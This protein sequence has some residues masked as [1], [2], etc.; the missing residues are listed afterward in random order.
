M[1]NKITYQLT[2]H[3]MHCASCV[4]TIE[5]ALL[6]LSAVQHAEVNFASKIATVSLREKMSTDE[7]IQAM[8]AA[9]YTATLN[10]NEDIRLDALQHEQYIL[11]QHKQLLKKTVVAFLMGVPAFI[12]HLIA[13]PSLITTEGQ[14]LG[15]VLGILAFITLIYS[16]G[17][18]FSGAWTALKMRT[19][20]MDTLIAAGTGIAWLYS[21]WVVLFPH[22]VPALA[23]HQYFE[24]TIFIIALVNLGAW[25]ESAA[26]GKTSAAIK[27]LL[28]LQPETAC[29]IRNN[30]EIILPINQVEINDIVRIKP[31]N[32]IPVDGVIIEGESY[33]DQAMLT[34]E[35]IPVSKKTGD[36]VVSGTVNKTG[37]FLFKTT[38]IGQDTTLSQIIKLVQQAQNTKPSIARLADKVAA[39][40]VPAIILIAIITALIWFMVGPSPKIIYMLVTA[41]SVLIIACPCA[42]GLAIPISVMTGIGKAAEYGVLIR[43]GEALQQAGNLTTI[44]LDKTGTITQGQPALSTI[45]LLADWSEEKILACAA[46]IEINS[47]HPL[48]QAILQAAK[49]RN[50]TLI[51]VVQFQ[52][53]VGHGVVASV[54]NQQVLL[55]N[56]KLLEK[57]Q[58]PL[59]NINLEEEFTKKG[60][61]P[62]FMVADKKIVAIFSIVDPLKADSA[63]AIARLQKL[64]VQVV[65]VTGDHWQTA[66]AIAAE[67][68][69]KQIFADT[70]PQHKS[71]IVANLQNKG[72]IVGMAGDGINDAP[73]LMQ[74]NVG[75]AVGSGIAVTVESAD[76][77]LLQGSL[78][79]IVNA[80][81]I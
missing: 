76:I 45:K 39:I 41:M 69:I 7:I 30:N 80:I 5:N 29:L 63:A 57:Y 34:G 24:S 18:F 66:Q 33:V 11:H 46:S 19:T 74:A 13:M 42:I 36:E 64:G 21:A 54:N 67:V 62:I 44:I 71:Q 38:K 17:H 35:A 9:G 53:E 59:N 73:A 40:F 16:G 50:C 58:V 77:T 8:K 81:E 48:G 3:D 25:L 61:T 15:I 31:G 79:S 37:S 68:G 32:R 55:G 22:T 60:Q 51:P 72:E 1:D 12:F 23:Q 47:E 43:N 65:M 70:L 56:K 14:M 27:R 4:N 26:R 6:K 10:S 49:E 78:H 20:N 2:V 28:E 52:A 75:F